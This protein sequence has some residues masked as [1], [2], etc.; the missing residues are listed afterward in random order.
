MSTWSSTQDES[1]EPAPIGPR[2][3]WTSVFSSL[4]VVAVS[5][6]A[7]TKWRLQV[8]AHHS[9]EFGPYAPLIWVC[10]L[11]GPGLFALSFFGSRIKE[12][13]ITPSDLIV[14]Q[15][16][17]TSRFPLA[18]LLSAE[19]NPTP[20]KG[21]VRWTGNNGVGA[22]TGRYR[23]GT[24]G[25]MRVFLTDPKYAVLLRWSDHA[26]VVSPRQPSVFID[27]LRPLLPSK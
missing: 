9:T 1:F 13:Q 16:F 2:V 27:S 14:R 23:S 22:I 26:V 24:F 19:P 3:L 4:A 7:V 6:I 8:A 12:I 17:R 5:A 25:P 10:Y 18:G 15:S 21:A 11:L 20:L